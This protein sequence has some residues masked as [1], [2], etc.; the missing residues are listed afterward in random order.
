MV[1]QDG[2]TTKI[3]LY[4]ISKI[5]LCSMTLEYY[6][7][8]IRPISSGIALYRLRERVVQAAVYKDIKFEVQPMF[9]VY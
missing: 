4:G 8:K 7:D 1:H 3:R 9:N 2:A 6:Y 5:K